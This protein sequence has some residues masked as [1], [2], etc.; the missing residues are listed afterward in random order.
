MKKYFIVKE[1]RTILHTVKKR[2]AKQI[3]TILR[4]NW[5]LKPVIEG[6]IEGRIEVAGR[7][8][9]RRKQLLD[10]LTETRGYWKLQEEALDRTL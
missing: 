7:R 9:G 10:D 4:R 6:R 8:G 1:D 2:K 5:L 3:G